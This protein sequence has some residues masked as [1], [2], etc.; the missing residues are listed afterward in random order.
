[1]AVSNNQTNHDLTYRWIR[2]GAIC[3]PLAILTY[4]LL[5]LVPLPNFWGMLLVSAFGPLMGLASV[6][7][8]HFMASTRKTVTLQIAV[9]ANIIAVACLTMMLIVQ[10]SLNIR[11]E[12][13]IATVSDPAAVQSLKSIWI[14]VDSVQLG[15]DVAWDVFI[16]LGTLL[17][18]INMLWHPRLGKIIG[19]LGIVLA[20]GLFVFNIYTFPTPPAEANLLDLGPLVALWYVVVSIMILFSLG[21]ARKRLAETD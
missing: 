12:N 20:L 1:M 21:W 4:A 11:M 10:Q 8:Y 5:V 3:G 19:M 18:A 16:V 14:G 17:F 6:G 7:F 13:T 9:V 15:M 2:L